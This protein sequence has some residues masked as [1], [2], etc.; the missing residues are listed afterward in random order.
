ML[1]VVSE[2]GAMATDLAGLLG[3]AIGCA[4]FLGTS[5]L[6]GALI[7]AAAARRPAATKLSALAPES[8]G[9]PDNPPASLGKTRLG[10]R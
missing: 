9:E 1:W 6:A 4:L 8:G 3:A 7:A 5:S 10:S 2:V